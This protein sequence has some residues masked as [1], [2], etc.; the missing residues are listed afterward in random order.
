MALLTYPWVSCVVVMQLVDLLTQMWVISEGAPSIP[1][2]GVWMAGDNGHDR[3]IGP[4]PGKARCCSGVDCGQS[5]L[6][7]SL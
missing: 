4:G 5:M 1:C 3:A 2:F 6:R 7:P